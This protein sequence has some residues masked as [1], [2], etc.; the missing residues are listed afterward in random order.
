MKPRLDR[1]TVEWLA[2]VDGGKE[3]IV[4]AQVG[5]NGEFGGCRPGFIEGFKMVKTTNL[6]YWLWKSDHITYKEL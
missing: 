1:S 4:R 3:S 6:K 2:D 5:P